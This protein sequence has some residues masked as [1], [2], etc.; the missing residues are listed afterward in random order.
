MDY[1]RICVNRFSLVYLYAVFECRRCNQE[2]APIVL[3]FFVSNLVLRYLSHLQLKHE[4]SPSWSNLPGQVAPV[5]ARSRR[6]NA[7]SLASC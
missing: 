1:Q 5:L 4:L 3:V 7:R 2:T 6:S